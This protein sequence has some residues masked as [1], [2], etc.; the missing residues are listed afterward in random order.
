MWPV[1]VRIIEMQKVNLLQIIL[2]DEFLLSVILQKAIAEWIVTMTGKIWGYARVSDDAQSLHLQLDALAGA[3]VDA[4][5]IFT[6]QVSGARPG[7]PGLDALLEKVSAGDCVAVWRLDRLGRSVSH[8][9]RLLEDFGSRGV[10]FRSLTEAID[11]SSAS[12][13]MIFNILAAF[14]GYERELIIER[15]RAGMRAAAA[16]RVHLGRPRSLSHLQR[17]HARRLREEGQSLKQIAALFQVHPAT[18]S[19]TV[20]RVLRE[21]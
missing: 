13:R 3:G 1:Q 21:K 20:H 11:T 6:D 14:A 9:V 19:R 2:D 4:K 8:L 16:R 5:M 18:I 17:E 15:V 10:M 12:G 7:R